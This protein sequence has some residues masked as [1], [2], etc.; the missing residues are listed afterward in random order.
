MGGKWKEAPLRVRWMVGARHVTL[1]G[2]H[3]PDNEIRGATG[4]STP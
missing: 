3:N 2:V 1:H 4:Y